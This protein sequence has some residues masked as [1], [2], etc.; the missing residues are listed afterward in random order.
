M[1]PN[2]EPSILMLLLGLVAALYV[3]TWWLEGPP[4]F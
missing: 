1:A 4:G 3:A 2:D